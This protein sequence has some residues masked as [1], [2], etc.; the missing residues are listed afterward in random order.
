MILLK[1]MLFF[2]VVLV[3]H[4]PASADTVIK[5]ADGRRY[6]IDV[7]KG[8]ANPPVIIALHGGGGSGAWMAK[9]SGMSKI[10]QA[11]GFAVI[12]P[13]G[14]GRGRFLTWNAGYCCAFAAKNRVDDIGFIARVIADAAN[15]FGIDRTNVFVTGMS[16]GG[17]MAER[18]GAMR[19]DLFRAVASVAGP[20][21]VARTTIKGRIPLMHIH[22]TADEVVPYQGGAGAHQVVGTSFTPVDSVIAAWAR[23]QNMRLTATKSVIDPVRRDKT[24]VEKTVYANGGSARVVLFKVLDGGHTWPGSSRSGRGGVSK[25]IDASAEIVR[26]FKSHVR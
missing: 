14:S 8:V 13:D 7:P 21:D 1:R 12:Y 11:N 15:R 17:M 22:G 16:N 24:S 6:Q 26:F 9:V 18:L 23:S 20:L 10:A 3:V 2:C 25:D 4:A 19:P 5:F